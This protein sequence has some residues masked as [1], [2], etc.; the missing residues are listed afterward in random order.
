MHVLLCGVR[1][2]ELPQ[3]F[4]DALLDDR[5]QPLARLVEQQQS[6][7]S[8]HSARNREHILDLNDRP[9]LTA[10]APAC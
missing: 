10:V 9:P 3:Q 5:R 8:H 4:A 2:A 1:W 6:R 7:I